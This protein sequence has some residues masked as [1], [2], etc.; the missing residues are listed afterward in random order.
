LESIGNQ[1]LSN[2]DSSKHRLDHYFINITP[3]PGFARFEGLDD[4]M[5]GRVKMLGR[6][7]VG[8]VVTTAHVAANQTNTEMD[9][10]IAGF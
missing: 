6:V 4:G 5:F 8:G 10:P 7:P 9:P 3:A 1:I 2:F